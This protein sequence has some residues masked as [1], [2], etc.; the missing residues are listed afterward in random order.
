MLAFDIIN[1]H[2]TQRGMMMGWLEQ[3]NLPLARQSEPM[4]WMA[5]EDSGHGRISDVGSGAEA[6]HQGGG[7]AMMPGMATQQELSELQA[8]QGRKAEVLFLQMMTQ[9][10]QG[11]VLM[12][13]TAVDL[14]DREN[15]HH[16]AQ[17]MVT[18]QEAEIELMTEICA[19]GTPSPFLGPQRTPDGARS[20]RNGARSGTMAI[21]PG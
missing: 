20:A 18:G 13:E 6:S 7:Y 14:S 19:S 8:A 15:V 4:A 21:G 2:A 11:G 17:Q 9:H 3:W 10:H 12:A 5:Q 16:L 1:T